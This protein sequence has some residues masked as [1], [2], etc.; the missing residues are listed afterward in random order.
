MGAKRRFIWGASGS[1]LSEYAWQISE[2]TQ[3]AWVG[4]DAAA[5]ITLLRATVEEELAFGME[6]RGVPREEMFARIKLA[7]AQWGLESLLGRDPASLSTGQTRRVAIASAML[8][9]PDG[10]VLDC[11]LDGCDAEAEATLIHVIERFDGQVSI[12]DRRWTKLAESCT[13]YRYEQGTLVTAEPL[14]AQLPIGEY[15]PL[16]VGRTGGAND[17]ILTDFCIERRD[18]KGQTTFSF[19]PRTLRFPAGKITHLRGPNGCGKTTLM[20][21]IANLIPSSGSCQTPP[22]GWMPTAMDQSFSQRSAL[23][24]VALGSDQEHAKAALAWCGLEDIAQQHPLDLN[25]SQ[26][27]LLA[28]ACAIVR[29]PGVLLLDEPTIGLDTAGIEA[30]ARLIQQFMAGDW[31]EHLAALGLS[32]LCQGEP[33]VIWSC[34]EPDFAAISDFVL[35][36]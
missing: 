21:A 2:D 29:G 36:L 3:V 24:E 22:V 4:N 25:S 27:R 31:H 12:C 14:R 35:E 11:P 5:H 30:L 9:H 23:R 26:R 6:Q 17:V 34:H 8:T 16:G 18:R 15:A 28:F 10:L 19:D 32:A 13:T 1:G 20:M 33:T 7:A